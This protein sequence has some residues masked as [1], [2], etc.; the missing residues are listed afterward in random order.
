MKKEFNLSEKRQELMKDL[1]GK[2]FNFNDLFRKIQEQDAE[3]IRLLKKCIE[4]DTKHRVIDDWTSGHFVEQI[5][6]LAGE[7]FQ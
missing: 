7:K 1:V 2:E 4:W 3:F 5:D 6:K